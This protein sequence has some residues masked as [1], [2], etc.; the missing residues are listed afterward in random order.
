[1]PH[2]PYI[3]PGDSKDV[4]K[5]SRRPKAESPDQPDMFGSSRADDPETS[6]AAAAKIAAEIGRIQARVLAAFVVHGEMTGEQ[7]EALPELAD[8]GPSTIRTRRSELVDRSQLE[9]SGKTENSRGNTVNIFRITAARKP[10]D[11]LYVEHAE[12][13]A[14]ELPEKPETKPPM[15]FEVAAGTK[16]ERCRYCRKTIFW[17]RTPQTGKP[18][19]IDC[20]AEDCLRPDSI[21]V[22]EPR[23]GRGINHFITCPHRALARA[24]ADAKRHKSSTK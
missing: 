12:H 23:P 3:D 2:E 24:D 7:L 10:L 14:S 1:M 9:A 19:P 17:I 18:C 8:L 20:D 4:G 15:F 13:V 16:P 11:E 6:I 21:H 22:D 5:R